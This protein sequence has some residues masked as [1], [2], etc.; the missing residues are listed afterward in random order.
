MYDE[1]VDSSNAIIEISSCGCAKAAGAIEAIPAAIANST[2][3]EL[4]ALV[5][6]ISH[7]HVMM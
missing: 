4:I 6:I 3:I 7:I 5:F 2:K 1:I